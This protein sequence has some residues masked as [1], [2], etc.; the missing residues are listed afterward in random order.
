MLLCFG[1]ARFGF[2]VGYYGK[3]D[4]WVSLWSLWSLLAP[5]D[6]RLPERRRD[7][8]SSH[9]QEPSWVQ[10]ARCWASTTLGWAI[11]GYSIGTGRDQ[12]GCIIQDKLCAISASTTRMKLFPPLGVNW[13]VGLRFF[14]TPSLSECGWQCLFKSPDMRTSLLTICW[15]SLNDSFFLWFTRTPGLCAAWNLQDLVIASSMEIVGVLIATF[16]LL[17]SEKYPE[18][19]SE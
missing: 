19:I 9:L 3:G 5:R 15:P 17:A 2:G 8:S 14:S 10:C 1:I 12:C 11:V 7:A 16:T 13:I 6:G 4:G 18:L